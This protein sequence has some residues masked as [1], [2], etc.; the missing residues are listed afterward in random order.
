MSFFAYHCT[1]QRPN[2]CEK[3]LRHGAIFTLKRT[4]NHFSPVFWVHI[5]FGDALLLTHEIQ[6]IEFHVAPKVPRHQ[7]V[8]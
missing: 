3:S 7:Q 8:V 4:K 2:S 1:L 6:I 5:D